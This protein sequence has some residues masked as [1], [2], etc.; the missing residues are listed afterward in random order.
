[1]PRRKG[2]T[3]GKERSQGS[4]AQQLLQAF[5]IGTVPLLLGAAAIWL[6]PMKPLIMERMWD[7]HA[8]LVVTLTP[9]AISVGE[10]IQV[11]VLGY[12]DS[13]LPVSSGILELRAVDSRIEP[14]TSN[15][16]W[17]VPELSSPVVLTKPQPATFVATAAGETKI[18]A[19]LRTKRG[20]YSVEQAVSISEREPG[21]TPT[22]HNFS[23][24]W[25]FT[26]GPHRGRMELYERDATLAG[27]Y[28][29][30]DGSRG[31]L[32]GIRDGVTFHASLV[33]GA[34]PQKWVI[35]AKVNRTKGYL[36]IDGNGELYRVVEGNW[37]SQGG[38]LPFYAVAKTK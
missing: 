22:R 9:A 3:D 10:E 1:M 23:G 12:P 37:K 2:H 19:E 33:R 17:E 7:E 30:E 5:V 15:L 36:E 29:L 28:S 31:A 35:R 4:L 24:T 13:P 38:A 20:T 6:S 18:R 21:G 25:D 14:I 16:H 11:T 8:S 34:T 27:R 32:D 26:L